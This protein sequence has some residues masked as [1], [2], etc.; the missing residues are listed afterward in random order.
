MGNREHK[1]NPSRGSYPRLEPEMD[2]SVTTTNVNFVK[3]SVI[4]RMFSCPS[5]ACS[6]TVKSMAR[7]SSGRD[8]RRFPL[9]VFT[10]GNGSF[11]RMQTHAFL[12]KW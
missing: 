5:L 2:S 4:T 9:A 11:A 7:P 3:T 12:H 6:S 8:A 10:L 1:A